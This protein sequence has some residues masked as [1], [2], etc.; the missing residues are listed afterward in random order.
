MSVFI[1][2]GKLRGSVVK[3]LAALPETAQRACGSGRARSLVFPWDTKPA[4]EH[5][6]RAGNR[7]LEAR[8][9]VGIQIVFARLGDREHA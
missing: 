7:S 6:A 1:K 2:V 9:A 4:D 5:L 3:R 8:T